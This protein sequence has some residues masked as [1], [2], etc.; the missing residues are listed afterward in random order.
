MFDVAEQATGLFH[1]PRIET[2]SVSCFAPS[3]S[4][5]KGTAPFAP[6]LKELRLKN[7]CLNERML[8][9]ILK[10]GSSGSLLLPFRTEFWDVLQAENVLRFLDH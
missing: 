4:V 3:T 2:L 10:V 6:T 5:W 1:I 9:V 8:A 7:G